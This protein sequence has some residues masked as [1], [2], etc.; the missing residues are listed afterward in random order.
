VSSALSRAL[1]PGVVGHQLRHGFATRVLEA[2]GDLAA[3]Q[4]LLGHASPATTR[5]YARTS[6][7]ALR[8]AIDKL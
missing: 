4:D 3:T 6:T 1:G 5:I 2:T 8:A 7:R